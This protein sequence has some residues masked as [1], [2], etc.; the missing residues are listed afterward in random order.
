MRILATSSEKFIVSQVVEHD[1]DRAGVVVLDNFR[2]GF[3]RKV[4]VMSSSKDPSQIVM[5]SKKTMQ[6]MDCVVHLAA[7]ISVPESVEKP[8]DY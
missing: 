1:Q 8:V 4:N 5:T 6:A 3:R 2:A 7:C